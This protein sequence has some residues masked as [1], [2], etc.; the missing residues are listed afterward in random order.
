MEEAIT[1]DFALIKA[2]KADRAGNLIFRKTARNFN[3]PMCKAAGIT[4][5]EVEEIIDVDQIPPEDI[6]VPS[7]Y[8]HRVIKGAK[9]EKRIEVGIRLAVYEGLNFF[10]LM[11]TKFVIGRNVRSPNPRPQVSRKHQTLQ[12]RCVSKLLVEPP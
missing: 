8:V 12:N 2:W 4:I 11:T 7:V 5:A 6:H 9:Y 3:P 10:E 1:G